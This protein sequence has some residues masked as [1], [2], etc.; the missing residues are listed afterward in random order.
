M[1]YIYKQK[2]SRNFWIKYYRN[3]QPYRESSGSEKESDAKRLLQIREGDIARG[4][5]VAP[6]AGQVMVDELI[7]DLKNEYKVNGRT[8]I[9]DLERRCRKHVLPFFG[10]RRASSITTADANTF[11]VARQDAGA[12]RAEINRELSVLKRASSLAAKATPPKVM[13]MPYIP[14]LKENDTRTGFFEREQFEQIHKHLPDYVQPVITFAYITGWRTLSEI[15][16]L[17]WR[18]V[19]FQAGTVRLDPQMAK[20]KE[21]REFPFTAELRKVLEE[22]RARAATLRR[23]EGIVCPWVFPRRGKR[24]ASYRKSWATA[25]KKAGL[26]GRIPHDFRRTAVRN[27]VRAGVSE[28]VAMQMTGHKTR[29]VFERYNIV[30]PQDLVEAARRLDGAAGIVS[31][32]VAARSATQP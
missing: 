17:E 6:K 26:P 28:K 9:K 25:C 20:N 15:L 12:S 30:S 5:P 11:I 21:G 32:I 31:G 27:L 10:G 18:H 14:T 8:S 13:T 29:S 22:Q 1:G 3:G 7:E 2:G 23:E 19:D 4:R 16:P 24:F